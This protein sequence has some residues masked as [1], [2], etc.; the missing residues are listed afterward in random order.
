MLAPW[1][2]LS[3][4]CLDCTR[5]RVSASSSASSFLVVCRRYGRAQGV[6]GLVRLRDRGVRLGR[7][8]HG[9]QGCSRGKDGEALRGRG[10]RSI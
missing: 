2:R 3:M 7:N 5:A 10:L 9:K 1:V 8:A 6:V 4:T